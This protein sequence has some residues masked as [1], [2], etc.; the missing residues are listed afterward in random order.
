MKRKQ[1]RA[2]S[3]IDRAVFLERVCGRPANKDLTGAD[4]ARKYFRGITRGGLIVFCWRHGIT[5]PRKRWRRIRT[6]RTKRR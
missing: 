4:I 1:W 6:V 2:L 3:A 5:L